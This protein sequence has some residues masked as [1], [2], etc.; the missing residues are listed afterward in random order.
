MGGVFLEDGGR[1]F[2]GWEGFP[3]VG[4]VSLRIGGVRCFT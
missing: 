1:S 4:R 3:W 2:L